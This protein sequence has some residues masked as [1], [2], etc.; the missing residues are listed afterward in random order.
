M[1]SASGARNALLTPDATEGHP[2]GRSR[3]VSV[4]SGRTAS[5]PASGSI[6]RA[7]SPLGTAL[8]QTSR[9]PSV[10]STSRAPLGSSA[11]R[12]VTPDSSVSGPISAGLRRRRSD[13]FGSA[14]A[15][16]D[17]TVL[18]PQRT[19]RLKEYARKKARET[20]VDDESLCQFI[21]SGGIYHMLVD[22]KANLLKKNVEEENTGLA[23]L[24]E[25]LDS[26]DFKAGLQSRLQACLLSPNITAYVTDT[27]IHVME[28]IKKN[29]E[30]F[31][32]PRGLLEDPELS[33]QLSRMVTDM[34]S[35]LRGNIKQRVR[36]LSVFMDSF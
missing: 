20:G 27:H 7:R 12:P 6:S 2:R 9:T 10:A 1:R 3:S 28:F 35:S 31:K 23:D 32:I 21:D 19:K 34:L 30:V 14:S 5:R 8:P 11:L 24:K 36:I 17:P 25:L 13:S 4:N 15:R 16:S 18:T 26:K 22:L 33:K 29:I